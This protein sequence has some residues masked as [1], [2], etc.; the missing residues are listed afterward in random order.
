MRFAKI[1]TTVGPQLTNNKAHHVTRYDGM[2]ML[3]QFGEAA[4]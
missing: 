2:I 3:G 1:N 4:G